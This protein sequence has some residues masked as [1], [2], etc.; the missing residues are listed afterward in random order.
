MVEAER[1]GKKGQLF[2]YTRE[3]AY[4]YYYTMSQM[5]L[6]RT[7]VVRCLGTVGKITHEHVPSA[8][9]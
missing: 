8:G 4:T 6:W 7:R 5:P 1:R 2:D 3:F 9:V